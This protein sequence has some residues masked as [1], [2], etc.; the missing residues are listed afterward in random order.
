MKLL[1]TSAGLKN[2]SIQETFLKFVPSGSK[3]AFI[4][5]AS[6]AEE[7]KDYI[8]NDI[9]CLN[10]LNM[11]V[12]CID[13]SESED[14]WKNIL[15]NSDVIFV[16]GGNTFYLL[17]ELR[18]S[19]CDD[20]LK[21]FVKSKFYVGVS[22][23]SIIVTPSIEI[24]SVEP[25]DPNDVG[26]TDFTGLGLIDFELS[27]HTPDMVPYENVKKYSDTRKNKV[28]AYDDNTA[29]LIEDKKVTIISEGKYKIF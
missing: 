20:I 16:D 14:K 29:I 18:K 7:N 3:I 2:R 24:A 4:T 10:N 23:G 27:P 9:V 22:A 15:T 21:A 13:I 1:L 17:D 25:G 12:N 5:T 11:D 6:N 26:I 28:Y 19:K 8:N